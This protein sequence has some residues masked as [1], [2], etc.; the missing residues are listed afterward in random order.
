[1]KSNL[2]I[3]RSLETYGLPPLTARERVDTIRYEFHQSSLAPCR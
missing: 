1:M 2:V 3:A